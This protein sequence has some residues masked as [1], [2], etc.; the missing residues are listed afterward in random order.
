M[1]SQPLGHRAQLPPSCFPA[2]SLGKRSGAVIGI[3]QYGHM[4]NPAIMPML[5][6]RQKDAG[7]QLIRYLMRWDWVASVSGRHRA[8]TQ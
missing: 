4:E 8:A 5:E 7:A 6:D 1:L 2:C 3:E